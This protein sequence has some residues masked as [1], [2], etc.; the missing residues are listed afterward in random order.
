MCPAGVAINPPIS[1]RINPS[2]MSL[3]WCDFG[4]VLLMKLRAT[5]RGEESSGP[6]NC[7][8][9]AIRSMGSCY[10]INGFLA[11]GRAGIDNLMARRACQSS[12]NNF[13]TVPRT[14]RTKNAVTAT[15]WIVCKITETGA[16]SCRMS[17]AAR[18]HDSGHGRDGRSSFKARRNGK[19]RVR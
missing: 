4:I 2:S 1:D 5:R 3:A 16:T 6:V 11:D 18:K 7:A 10:G 12:N 13:P 9:V 15:S 17:N 14:P 8:A 19:D